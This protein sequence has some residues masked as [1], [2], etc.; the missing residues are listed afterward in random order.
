MDI[1]EEARAQINHSTIESLFPGGRWDGNDSYIVRSP[2]RIDHEAG[3]FHINSDGLFYDFADESQGDLISLV[4]Q[5][6]HVSLKEAAEK[7][8]RS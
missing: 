1:F 7:N 6:Y 8:C 4:S 3:S 2:L 5:V